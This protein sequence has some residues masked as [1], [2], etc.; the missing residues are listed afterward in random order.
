MNWKNDLTENLIW[1]Q[2][3]SQSIRLQNWGNLF[4]PR[5]LLP[6][7]A[8]LDFIS[9]CIPVTGFLDYPPTSASRKKRYGMGGVQSLGDKYGAAT[10]LRSCCVVLGDQDGWGTNRLSKAESILGTGMSQIYHEAEDTLGGC[11]DRHLPNQ[12]QS[13]LLEQQGKSTAFTRPGYIDQLNT[14]FGTFHTRD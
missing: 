10:R 12:G 9:R 1:N 11:V 6:I 14:M 5:P 3:L 7:K 13:R 4:F 8:F 2:G